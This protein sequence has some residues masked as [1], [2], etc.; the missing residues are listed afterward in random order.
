VITATADSWVEV[1]DATG[2]I[3]F[4]K[5]MHAGDSWPVPDEPGLTMTAGNAGG[6]V[7]TI[8]GKAGAP[9]GAN[10]TV[11]RGYALTPAAPGAA[12]PASAAPVSTPP[13]TKP[14]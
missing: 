2:N 14:N 10:G 13:P 5:T 11:L 4:S 7:I 8:G 3:L 6:T 9:L 12:T 1:Q